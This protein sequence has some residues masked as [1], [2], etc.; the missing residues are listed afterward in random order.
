MINAANNWIVLKRICAVVAA[1]GWSLCAS[2]QT[3]NPPYKLVDLRVVG[4]AGQPFQ[5]TNNGII[6]G[7]VETHDGTADHAVIYFRHQ[8]FDIGKPGLGGANSEAI[9]INGWGQVVGGANNSPNADPRERTFA[10]SRH[11]EFLR[12]RQVACRFCGKGAE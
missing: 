8:M 4:P 1:L 7:A 9:G 6:T 5:I 12:L 10:A 11:L 3:N 2:A